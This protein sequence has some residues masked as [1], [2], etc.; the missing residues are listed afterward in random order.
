MDGNVHVSLTYKLSLNIEIHIP[1]RRQVPLTAPS[2]PAQIAETPNGSLNGNITS[3]MNGGVNGGVN[4]GMNGGIS[5][6][7]VSG[8]VWNTHNVTSSTPG[9]EDDLPSNGGYRRFNS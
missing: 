5:P 2:L 6:T 7:D 9:F 8:G 1:Q 4:G 3:G